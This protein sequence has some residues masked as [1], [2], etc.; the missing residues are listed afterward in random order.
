M[1]L[2]TQHEEHYRERPLQRKWKPDNDT[3]SQDKS[4]AR[5][6]CISCVYTGKCSKRLAPDLISLSAIKGWSVQ[7]GTWRPVCPWDSLFQP[8]PPGANHSPGATVGT[9]GVRMA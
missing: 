7:L 2:S 1:R 8:P 3:V 6:M 9:G 4:A 5:R